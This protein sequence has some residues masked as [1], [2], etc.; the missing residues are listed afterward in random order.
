MTKQTIYKKDGTLKAREEL[1]KALQAGADPNEGGTSLHEAVIGGRK[2]ALDLLLDFGADID[3]VDGDGDTA[4]IRACASTSINALQR[5]ELIER[6]VERGASI[7]HMN[8]RGETALFFAARFADEIPEALPVLLRLG[9]DPNLENSW[10]RLAPIH[11]ADSGE[12]VLLLLQHGADPNTVDHSGMTARE[13]ARLRGPDIHEAFLAWETSQSKKALLE[14]L[15]LPKM[16][17]VP[18]SDP[19]EE[20][21][22]PK[23]KM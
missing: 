7:D 2:D 17:A 9:A 3:A 21:D 10:S 16:K 14:G 6:L 4:L 5:V 15:A 1:A 19:T 13:Q 11:W 20:K 8:D 22:K 23:F 18:D 12:A